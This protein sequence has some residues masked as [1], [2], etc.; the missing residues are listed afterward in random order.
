M[1]SIIDTLNETFAR[2]TAP[3]LI[4][5]SHFFQ[6]PNRALIWLKHAITPRKRHLNFAHLKKLL[7]SKELSCWL[8][9]TC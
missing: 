1:S 8:C 5:K 4:G 6:L 3:R 2:T 9:W 7:S